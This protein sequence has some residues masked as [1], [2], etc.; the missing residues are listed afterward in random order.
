MFDGL[1]IVSMIMSGLEYIKESFEREIPAEN[2]ANKELIDRDIMNDVPVEQR[3][4]NAQNGKYKQVSTYQ[5][6]HRGSDGKIIIENS[7]LY[8]EDLMNCGSVQTI[9]WVE[10][11]K[12]NL[13]KEEL[14]K[15]HKRIKEKYKRLCSY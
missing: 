10:Q 13:S 14:E 8:H 9:K 5:E 2:W 1:F 7:K 3:I 12:Y 11:G 6:P 15:E 4:M